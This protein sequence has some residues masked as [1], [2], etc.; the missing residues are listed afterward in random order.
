MKSFFIHVGVAI[1]VMI[2]LNSCECHHFDE[3]PVVMKVGHVLCT[4]GSVMPLCKFLE[5]TKE[6]VGIVFYVNNDPDIPG[7]GYAVYLNDL[8]PA[9]FAE[10]LGVDQ[11]TSCSLTAHDGNANTFALYDCKDVVSPMAEQVFSMWTYQQSAYIPSVQQLRLLLGAKD[12][13][14]ERIA[15]CGGDPLPEAASECWYWSSTEVE[16]QATAKAWLFSLYS[17]AVQETPKNVNQKLRPIIT[18]NR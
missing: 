16:G 3:P 5:S 6:A 10:T 13:I 4:D 9:C 18:I 12:Q 8:E 17:G 11:K 7:K 2:G 15:L 14:N 1:S